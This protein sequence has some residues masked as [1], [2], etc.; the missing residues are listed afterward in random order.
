LIHTNVST[1]CFRESPCPGKATSTA[2]IDWTIVS[3]S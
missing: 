3:R 2:I 1:G